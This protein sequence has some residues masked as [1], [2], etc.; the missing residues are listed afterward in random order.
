MGLIKFAE[1]LKSKDGG[2]RNS[3][4]NCSA[5]NLPESA[6]DALRNLVSRL[7]YQLFSEFPAC[8]SIY[9][10]SVLPLSMITLKMNSYSYTKP[11]PEL[12]RKSRL[13]AQ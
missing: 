4:Q 9:P 2:R 3:A 8:W 12:V 5:E 13:V 1:I 11:P 6:P 7:Q 10:V